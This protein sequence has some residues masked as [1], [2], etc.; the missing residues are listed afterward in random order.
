[1]WLDTLRVEVESEG[2]EVDI[3][4]SF[5]IAENGAFYTVSTG[6]NTEFSGGNSAA[7]EK[8][9]DRLDI[10]ERLLPNF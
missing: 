8:E 4:S 5:T 2:D 3:S 6:K 7:W 10:S 1:M 9:L